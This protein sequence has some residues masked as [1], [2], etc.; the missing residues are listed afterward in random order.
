[1]LV[2]FFMA[3][4][5]LL[6][7]PMLAMK[8]KLK[9]AVINNYEL[10]MNSKKIYVFFVLLVLYLFSTLRSFEMGADYSNYIYYFTRFQQWYSDSEFG[11]TVL[12]RIAYGLFGDNYIGLSAIINILIFVLFY[13][14][15]V[16][17][18][19]DKFIWLILLVFVLN[20]YLYIQ[21]TFNML[22][23]GIAMCFIIN[24]YSQ[25][26]D[27]K[28]KNFFAFI[29]IGAS[30]HKLSLV[31]LLLPLLNRINWNQKKLF[32]CGSIC[33]FINLF[34]PNLSFLSPIFKIFNFENYT[35]SQTSMFNFKM[36]G[37]FVYLVFCMVLYFYN[38]LYRNK[39]EKKLI[40][41]YLISLSFLLLAVKSDAVYRIYIV[42]VYLTLPAIDIILT[43]VDNTRFRLKKL[44]PY[45]YMVY[46]M[47]FYLIFFISIN[48]NTNY[49][50]FKF[51]F[52]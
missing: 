18:C 31:F 40:E 46:Y 24:A 44:L 34:I 50:P 19:S 2:Y 42:L 28:L 29:L 26:L 39:S 47:F 4:M 3:I 27:N 8:W 45:A 7:C 11:F 12:Y 30:F 23:Q 15:V 21:S 20:P 36:F 41:L 43:N 17:N 16:K 9:I 37:V 13:K 25:L 22:R 5:P 10:I 14:Y 51:Y 6:L 49:I 38:D 48:G 32:L 1:M 52:N 33:F 35:S